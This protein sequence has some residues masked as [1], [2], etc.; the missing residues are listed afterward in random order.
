MPK[1]LTY[2]NHSSFLLMPDGNEIPEGDATE[3]QLRES[4]YYR[5]GVQVG[6]VKGLGN[7]EIGAASFDPSRE[8]PTDGV[9]MSLDRDGLNRLIRSLQ[10]AGRES[11]GTDAWH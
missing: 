9:F 2:S 11:F 4:K 10:K 3:E 6:W 8:M 5:R 1:E 7:V